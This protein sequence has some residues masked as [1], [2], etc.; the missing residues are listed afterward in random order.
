[1]QT[2]RYRFE[3]SGSEQEIPHLARSLEDRLTNSP[4]CL[5]AYCIFPTDSDILDHVTIDLDEQKNVKAIDLYT[6][7]KLW[8]NAEEDFKDCVQ[9]NLNELTDGNITLT[10]TVQDLG[11]DGKIPDVLY[12][13]STEDNLDKILQEGL[14]PDSGKNSYKD[15]DHHVYLMG[16]EDIAPWLSVLKYKDH[17]VLLK[18]R[19]ESLNIEP[20]RHFSDRE[21]IPE[22]YAEYR[23][24]DQIPPEAISQVDF[25]K[26]KELGNRIAKSTTKQ[27]FRAEDQH[28]MLETL[29]GLHRTVEMNLIDVPQAN[30]MQQERNNRMYDAM[31]EQMADPQAEEGLPWDEPSDKKSEKQ[32]SAS[33]KPFSS[34]VEIRQNECSQTLAAMPDVEFLEAVRTHFESHTTMPGEKSLKNMAKQKLSSLNSLTDQIFTFDEK[35]PLAERFAKARIRETSLKP[36]NRFL[37]QKQLLEI[38]TE[39]LAELP[40]TGNSRICVNRADA[41]LKK[42]R[43]GSV[44]V[45]V[46]D[47]GQL[48]GK[49]SDSFVKNNPMNV[50]SCR[51]ELQISDYSNGQL[52]NVAIRMVI[53]TDLMSGDTIEMD[54]GILKG[55]GNTE[56]MEQ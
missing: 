49:L 11:K 34:L 42:D 47:S 43:D 46:K 24:K 25:T 38:K 45:T 33:E 55:L 44:L 31:R 5:M 36:G 14:L 41:E 50:E 3:A 23:T 10:G 18:I 52:K 35:E 37:N 56:T 22:G 27:F 17:P 29:T 30:F 13:L 6:Y 53:D 1:M 48:I 21:Y 40:I 26:E 12:R 19:T 54:D 7:T 28:E 51:A 9:E 15:M 16:E 4:D 32:V 20:G 8:E 39:P 2:Y